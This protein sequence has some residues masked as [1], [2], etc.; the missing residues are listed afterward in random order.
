ML[1]GS[2]DLIPK[3]RTRCAEPAIPEEARE[4]AL[5]KALRVATTSLVQTNR[6]FH[7]MLRDTLLPR[8]LSGNLSVAALDESVSLV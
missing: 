1:G 2:Q 5:R 4:D 7:R 3:R 6:A 8:L